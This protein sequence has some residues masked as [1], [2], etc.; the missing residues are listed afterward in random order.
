MHNISLI[1]RYTLR[2]FHP[3]LIQKSDFPRLRINL[4]LIM[5]TI[6]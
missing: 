2:R 6:A 1:R 4:K 5:D 3:K